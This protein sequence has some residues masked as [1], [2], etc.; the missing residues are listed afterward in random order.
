[1]VKLMDVRP[2]KFNFSPSDFLVKLSKIS[3][4]TCKSTL[5]CGEVEHKELVLDCSLR[6]RASDEGAD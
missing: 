3:F 2:I 1:M 4:R 6:W 5:V